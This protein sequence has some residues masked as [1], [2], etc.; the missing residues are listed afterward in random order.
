M[1]DQKHEFT[2]E[3]L[4]ELVWSEPMTKAATQ[5]DIS[6]VGL[7]K[8][9]LRNGIPVPGRGYWRRLETGKRVKKTPLPARPNGENIILRGHTAAEA[10]KQEQVQ[11]KSEAELSIEELPEN[12][13]VVSERL[14]NPHPLTTATKQQLEKWADQYGITRS[15]GPQLFRVRV[16]KPSIPRALRIIDALFKAFDKRVWKVKAATYDRGSASV[17]IDEEQ[18]EF[19]LE[20]PTH[21]RAHELTAQE[22]KDKERSGSAWAPRFDYVAGGKLTLKITSYYWGTGLRTSWKDREGSTVETK[23]NE[24]LAGMRLV[25][26]YRRQETNRREEEERRREELI[27]RQREIQRRKDAEAKAVRALFDDAALWKQ[28]HRV[29]EYV[30]A[31]RTGAAERGQSIE[32]SSDI[33]QWLEWAESNAH[34]KDPLA[35][36]FERADWSLPQ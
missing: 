22:K 14:S 10:A 20:E 35:K 32:P 18:V 16:S 15:G 8:I 6:D 25:A 26:G 34:G 11:Q 4:Y 19:T 5:F 1:S 31:I 30:A 9:C 24:F 33:G 36:A 27:A 2:R 28:V 21:Q 3:Q 17:T 23:L 7:K 12:R 29:R 13:L